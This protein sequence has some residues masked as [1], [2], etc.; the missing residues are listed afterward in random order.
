MHSLTPYLFLLACLISGLALVLVGKAMEASADRAREAMAAQAPVPVV[1]SGWVLRCLQ[2]L[3]L[4]VV[5]L[6]CLI[7]AF[8]YAA[9]A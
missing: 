2:A 4:C 9:K 1:E 3:A 7:L 8:G 5:F 6:A